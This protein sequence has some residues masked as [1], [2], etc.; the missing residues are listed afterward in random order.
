MSRPTRTETL[1]DE[2]WE[3]CPHAPSGLTKGEFVDS[4]EAAAP[5]LIQSYLDSFALLSD[6][7]HQDA[8]EMAVQ[9]HVEA[10]ACF[11]GLGSCGTGGCKHG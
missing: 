3:H 2:C 1:C 11:V 6:M 9:E 4:V 10:A 7:T 5:W 8:L